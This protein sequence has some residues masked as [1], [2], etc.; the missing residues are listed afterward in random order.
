[1]TQPA[2]TKRFRCMI[3]IHR[4]A[5]LGCEDVLAHMVTSLADQATEIASELRRVK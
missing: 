1:M 3:G 4:W 5:D 2:Q